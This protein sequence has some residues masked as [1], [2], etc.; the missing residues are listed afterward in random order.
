MYKIRKMTIEVNGENIR[1]MFFSDGA[2]LIVDETPLPEGKPTKTG[3]NIGKTTLLRAIDFVLGAKRNSLFSQKSDIAFDYL[4]KNLGLFTI[5]FSDDET[6]EK[7]KLARGFNNRGIVFSRINDEKI[8][9]QEDYWS[10]LGDIFFTKNIDKESKPTYRQ[11]MSRVVRYSSIAVEETFKYL[12][13][14][15]GR[16]YEAIF[17]YIFNIKLSVSQKDLQELE[18][19]YSS[20]MSFYNRLKSGINETQLKFEKDLR[21][22]NIKD[23]DKQRKAILQIPNYDQVLTQLVN[24]KKNIGKINQQIANTNIKKDLLEKQKNSLDENNDIVKDSELDTLYGDAVDLMG[25]VPKAF[26]QVVDFVNRMRVNRYNFTLK[27][28]NEMNLNLSYLNVRKEGL[29]NSISDNEHLLLKGNDGEITDIEKLISDYKDEAGSLGKITEKLE[30]LKQSEKTV[31]EFKDKLDSASQN[32]YTE[33][34]KDRINDILKNFSRLYLGPVFKYLYG[35]NET[36]YV[37]AEIGKSS[38][39]TNFYKL[40]IS[41]SIDAKSSGSMQALTIAFDIAYLKFAKEEKINTPGFVISDRKELVDSRQL[42]R[43][44]N[45]ANSNDIQIIFP[46]LQDK[47]DDKT[48]NED[49]VLLRLSEDDKLYRIEQNKK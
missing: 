29:L 36:A 33:E 34:N 22:E 1:E 19:S 8:S 6:D 25:D 43:L 7:V 37:F 42:S 14:A 5:E 44:I 23:L 35:D 47:M 31:G 10:K 27:S 41:N 2:N 3:N 4:T 39:G 21:I 9:N 15:T 30:Q 11:L 20:E 12:P 46:I 17:F 40:D 45:Y 49:N 28:L 32:I 26:N 16:D 48:L 24:D 18:D 13:V 38:K